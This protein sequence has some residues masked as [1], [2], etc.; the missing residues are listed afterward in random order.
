MLTQQIS[1]AAGERLWGCVRA[2]V[3]THSEHMT[4]MLG[5]L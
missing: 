5:F 2:L 4:L 1:P 3:Q